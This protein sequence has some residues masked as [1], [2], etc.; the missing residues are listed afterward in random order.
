[1][2]ISTNIY[3]YGSD[4]IPHTH[5]LGAFIDADRFTNANEIKWNG[6]NGASALID[7]PEGTELTVFRT[8]GYTSPR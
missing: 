2:I 1:M 4:G 5:K 6:V 3:Y 7:S 8:S